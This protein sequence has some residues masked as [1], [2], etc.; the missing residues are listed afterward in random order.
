M[1]TSSIKNELASSTRA[2][3]SLLNEA[4]ITSLLLHNSQLNRNK[5]NKDLLQ[6]R[7]V[8]T[9]FLLKQGCTDQSTALYHNN[10]D[11]KDAEFGKVS[12]PK[13]QYE[14]FTSDAKPRSVN[15]K[16]FI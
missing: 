3:C 1:I 4:G 2:N 6:N 10:K 13:T 12:A 9:E 14:I 5:V 11:T 8:Q 16:R 7:H 15:H